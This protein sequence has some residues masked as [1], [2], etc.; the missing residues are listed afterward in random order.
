MP[1]LP[2]WYQ[3]VPDILAT[4][5]TAGMPPVLD[6]S[7]IED[8]FRVRRRQAIRLLG[9]AN[10]YQVGKTFIVDR[11]SVID[12]LENLE[13]SGAA[14]EA[15]ARKRRVALAITEVA[16]YAEAQRVEIRTSPDALKR[17]PADLPAGIDLVAPGKLQISYS[18]AEDLLARIVEL[19]AAATNDF[20]AFRKIYEGGR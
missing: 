16:N 4:L 9:A 6:R 19:A 12:Y 20:A 17:R 8:L 15:R 13:N 2:A 18:G 5:R 1:A 14:P 7:A 3:R 10:G 11:Q